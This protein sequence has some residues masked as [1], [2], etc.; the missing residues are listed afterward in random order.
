MER[1][2]VGY[3]FDPLN[4]TFDWFIRPDMS[5]QGKTYTDES[6]LA[7]INDYWLVNM[8]TGIEKNGLRIEAFVRN[9]F[10]DDN[11]RAAAS[12]NDFSAQN[13]IAG[14][15]DQAIFITPPEKRTF[16]MKAV[17]EF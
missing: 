15:A 11:Y 3:L 2:G 10:D 6:N 1:C 13:L 16:G 4:D 7:W 8:R 12:R 5:Y 17:M 14:L 9:L